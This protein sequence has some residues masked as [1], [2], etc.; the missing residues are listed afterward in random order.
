MCAIAAISAEDGL[1]NFKIEE[2]PV[3]TYSFGKYL[4]RLRK[5]FKD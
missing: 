2:D 3:G 1:V 5:K 4:K